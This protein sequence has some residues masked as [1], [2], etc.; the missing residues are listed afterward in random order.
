MKLLL[1]YIL[2]LFF[3]NK[4]PVERFT[5]QER[6]QLSW[7]DFKGVPPKNIKNFA[8]VNSGIGYTFSSKTINSKNVL[9]IQVESYFYP[10]LSW[11]K[12]IN[13]NNLNLL[14]HEQLHWDIS[15]L[16]A[17]KLRAAY[18]RYVPQKNPKKEIDF[19]F[20]KFEKERQETQNI[21]DL[22][23]KHGLIKTLQIR[24]NDKIKEELF[25]TSQF[26]NNL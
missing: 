7:K 12:N 26:A 15:E 1:F 16:Y 24:W 4:D 14:E 22:K 5:Y 25:K 6:S 3:L 18:K 9:S 20:K 2:S 8:S 21:Y 10:Q 19:I 23:T 11:K 17:R 13:E